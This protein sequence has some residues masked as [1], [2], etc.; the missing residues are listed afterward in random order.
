MMRETILE[1][2]AAAPTQAKILLT[3][4]EPHK[5]RIDGYQDHK[6]AL[7]I[8]DTP[9]GA[10]LVQLP[11]TGTIEILP[12]AVQLLSEGRSYRFNIWDLSSDNPLLLFAGTFV[13]SESIAPT[14]V[15]V[16]TGFLAG[17]GQVDGPARIVVLSRTA[18]QGLSE[19]AEDTIYIVTE[20]A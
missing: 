12:A 6:L 11:G 9:G 19:P 16:A 7:T 1:P 2:G 4:D 17:F 8:S 15:D 20:A 14:G 13:T 3:R 5:I 10:A 18:Y